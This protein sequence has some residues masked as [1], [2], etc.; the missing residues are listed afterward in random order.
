MLMSKT[1]LWVDRELAPHLWVLS[2]ML[3]CTLVLAVWPQ[4]VL[5]AGY[6]CGMQMLLGLR[7][8]FC[9]M[10]R[11]FAAMM[12]GN[13]PTQNPCS[14]IAAP[15]VYVVYPVAVLVGWRR[16]RLDWF[17]GRALGCGVAVALVLMTVLNNLR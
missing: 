6:R 3:L 17:H 16:K 8:P 10:T 7:C 1:A 5:H 15:V 2:A 11:D 13:R 9:G 12:H 14:W 4:G